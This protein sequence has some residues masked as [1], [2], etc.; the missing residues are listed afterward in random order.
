MADNAR[1]IPSMVDGF[2]PGQRKVLYGTIKRNLKS[3]IKVAQLGMSV[4]ENTAYHHG[5]Q[6]LIM[7]IV[8]MA[9]NFVGSNNLN[10]LSPNGQFGSRREGGKDAAAARYIFTA[11]PRITRTIFHPQDDPILSYLKE[12]DEE[13]EPEWYVPIIPMVLINGADGIG[14]GWSTNVP[15]YNP[16]DVVANIRRRLNG[17]E[18]QPMMPWYRNFTGNIEPNG[19]DRFKISGNIEKIA[20]DKV[21]ITELPVRTWTV[22]YKEE[23]LKAWVQGTDNQPQL[24]EDYEE[25]DTTTTIDFIVTLNSKQMRAAEA[26]GL[27]EYFK[28]N[29]SVGITNMVCF[30]PEGKV[31]KYA[32]PEEILEEFFMLRFK[33]Y[34]LRKVSVVYQIK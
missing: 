33:Y 23:K 31:K 34:Q 16:S 18:Y 19:N 2:K 30:T 32:S 12:D 3:E 27:H 10:L 21:R 17:Q 5:E 25:H 22:P 20:E 24:I 15:N 28:L 29:S 8:N 7:T 6:S 26:K 1:S 13:I 11:I 9:Q 14:T 4:A